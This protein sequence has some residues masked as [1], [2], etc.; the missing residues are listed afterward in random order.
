MSRS[1]ICLIFC[2]L[3]LAACQTPQP[4]SPVATFV[5]FKQFRDE[6]WTYWP[7]ARP[8]AIYATALKDGVLWVGTS[9]GVW[10]V[11][12]RTYEYVSYAQ[13]GEITLLL[14]VENGRLWAAGESS[15]FYF[16]GQ[17]WSM[18]NLQTVMEDWNSYHLLGLDQGGDLWL[19]KGYDARLRFAG[20]AP[21]ANGTMTAERVEL[22]PNPESDQCGTWVALA[23]RRYSYVSDFECKNLARL[24]QLGG[25]RDNSALDQDGSAWWF[26]DHT[27]YHLKDD[28]RTELPW[29]ADFTALTP[30][31]VEGVWLGTEEGLVRADNRTIQPISLGLED[32]QLHKRPQNLAVD[33]AGNVWVVTADGVQNLLQGRDS[34]EPVTDFGLDEYGNT[35]PFGPIA[36]AHEGGIWA[37]H[38]KD[39]WRFG[40]PSV[41]LPVEAPLDARCRLIRLS[42][43]Q[44]GN[45]WSPSPG[46]GALQYI[47]QTN[48]WVR[49]EPESAID[50]VL[51]DTTGAIYVRG[52]S[53][54]YT[55]GP[56][57]G[58]SVISFTHWSLRAAHSARELDLVFAMNAQEN[59]FWVA[60]LDTGEMQF[61][62]KEPKHALK[63]PF[64]VRNLH[65]VHVDKAGKVWLGGT[66]KLVLFNGQAWQ[67]IATPSLGIIRDIT[68][69]SL[70]R[71][72]IAGDQGIARYDPAKDKQ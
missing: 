44:A 19:A 28:Q 62:R 22:F 30:D 10:R 33:L 50:E 40:G 47:P 64:Q 38:G 29:S 6:A 57:T 7:A 17:Q 13:L 56:V 35:R 15:L 58:S 49:H 1:L 46:C 69:D 36:A 3:A 61:Y 65:R 11:D 45:V 14:P 60:S 21:A 43:D 52:R 8:L 67:H 31:L 72:L 20:H 71:I 39:L 27:L 32:Y 26:E 23:T 53:G 34:W 18:A 16:D 42:V 59:G 24:R 4:S 51:S 66:S 12:P 55:S 48:Q 54:L 9:S 37:T 5:T 70:G 25:P 41:M 2:T 63:M 68:S